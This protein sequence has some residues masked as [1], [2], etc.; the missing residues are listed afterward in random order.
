MSHEVFYTYPSG[1]GPDGKDR[2]TIMKIKRVLWFWER[3]VPVPDIYVE[4][5]R[6]LAEEAALK[7][8]LTQL[9]KDKKQA[10]EQIKQWI[11]FA[12]ASYLE[13]SR[14]KSRKGKKN[15]SNQ[16]PM[17]YS[18]P[19]SSDNK[20]KSNHKTGPPPSEIVAYAADQLPNSGNQPKKGNNNNNQQQR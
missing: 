13:Y 20:E 18:L 11:D 9:E 10:K 19:S 16:P 17:L 8:Q 1:V 14:M 15:K 4:Y 12:K 6:L 7:S 2:Y 3:H 5:D